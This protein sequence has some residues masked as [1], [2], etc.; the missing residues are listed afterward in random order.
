[1][2]LISLH[3]TKHIWKIALYMGLG[4]LPHSKITGF[5]RIWLWTSANLKA[6]K[7]HQD[8]QRQEGNT[9]DVK[10][11]SSIS[12]CWLCSSIS[13]LLRLWHTQHPCGVTEDTCIARLRRL[14]KQY[15]V[16]GRSQVEQWEVDLYVPDG[17]LYGPHLTEEH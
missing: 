9:E 5:D 1:M 2:Q 11:P 14:I 8:S 7:K 12:H 10:S 3:R 15:P 4:L 13:Q 6:F 17:T 16:T